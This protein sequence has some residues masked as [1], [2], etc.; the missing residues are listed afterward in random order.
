MSEIPI[1]MLLDMMK[2]SSDEGTLEVSE[3]AKEL[4]IKGWFV[5][6]D[7]EQKEVNKH[8]KPKTKS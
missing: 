5:V 6:N 4:R 8:G 3:F 1:D 2:A 7:I